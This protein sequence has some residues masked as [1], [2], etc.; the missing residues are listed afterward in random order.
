MTEQKM[1]YFIML[2]LCVAA[3]VIIIEP[4]LNYIR[5]RYWAMTL[6]TTFVALCVLALGIIALIGLIMP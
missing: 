6:P 4:L 3:L 5:Q 1:M 2:V